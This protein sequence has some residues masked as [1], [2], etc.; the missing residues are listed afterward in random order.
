MVKIRAC[1]TAGRYRSAHKKSD[2][3]ESIITTPAS[4]KPRSPITP[5]RLAAFRA[6]REKQG[7][8]AKTVDQQESKLQK[9]A[10]FLTSEGKPLEFD[11]VSAWLDSLE[12][13]SKTKAQ[14]LLAGSTFWKWAI[15]YDEQ[16]KKDFKDKANPFADHDL[17]KARKGKADTSRKAFSVADIQKIYRT[18]RDDNQTV[19]CDLI[20]LGA[21]TGCRIEELCKLKP[22]SIVTIDGIQCFNIED[23]K[24]K[25]G[26]RHVPVHSALKPLL[27]RLIKDTKDGYLLPSSGGN[28]YG[29][30]SD[31]LSKA[32][33]RLKTSLGYDSRHVFHSVRAMVITQLQRADVPGVLIAELVGHETGTVTFDVY[34]GGHSEEQKAEAIQ[35]LSYQLN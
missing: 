7:L 25:A 20:Q 4:Y 15:R 11:T 14:Y 27:D 1:L 29:I 9:L 33:G 13:S 34:A 26:I 5:S 24:T 2:T 6:F 10:A 21:Y 18:A 35:R 28:K 30:R 22:E 3:P 12:L 17:P 16:W 23:S 19:L 31:S 32:F 8:P